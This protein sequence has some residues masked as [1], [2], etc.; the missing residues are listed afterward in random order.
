MSGYYTKSE[1]VD[2]LV[3]IESYKPWFDE[4][5]E[6]GECDENPKYQFTFEMAA[7]EGKYEL[8]R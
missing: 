8:R 2:A 3:D 4:E 6:L 5:L 7:D 1:L